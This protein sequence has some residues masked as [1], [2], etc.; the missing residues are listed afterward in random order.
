M[1]HSAFYFNSGTYRQENAGLTHFFDN[2][3]AGGV[4]RM[5]AYRMHDVDPIFF[6]GGFRFV[7]RV[8]DVSDEAGHKC[9]LEKGGSPSGSPQASFVNAY[10]WAYVWDRAETPKPQYPAVVLEA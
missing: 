7:W 10:T 9:T 8:G 1:T 6:A 2:S 4:V 5:S 3:S